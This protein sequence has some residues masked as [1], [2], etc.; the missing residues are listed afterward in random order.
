[1]PPSRPISPPKGYD[2]VAAQTTATSLVSRHLTAMSIGV[3]VILI[4]S[5]K[6]PYVDD[7]IWGH[8]GFMSYL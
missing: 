7:I 2:V 1:M 5:K 4:E 8:A 3:S 6:Q